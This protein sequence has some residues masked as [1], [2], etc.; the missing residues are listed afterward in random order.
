MKYIKLYE[1]SNQEYYT[2]NTILGNTKTMFVDKIRK[3]FDSIDSH[4]IDFPEC[5]A[6]DDTEYEYEMGDKETL[7]AFNNNKINKDSITILQELN[8][9]KKDKRHFRNVSQNDL[10]NHITAIKEIFEILETFV[11]ENPKYNAYG[12]DIQSNYISIMIGYS[13]KG[14]F[15]KMGDTMVRMNK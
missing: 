15:T 9:Y 7:K 14:H 10:I 8:I 12:L 4:I 6:F 2:F 3:Y 11:K 1:E 5:R 13:L